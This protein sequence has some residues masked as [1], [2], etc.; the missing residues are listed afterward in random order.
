MFKAARLLT[1]ATGVFLLS[2][3]GEQIS[4]VQVQG[5]QQP[6]SNI[7][8]APLYIFFARTTKDKFL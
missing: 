5:S 4:D 2:A 1:L 3:C 6:N 7:I 8:S